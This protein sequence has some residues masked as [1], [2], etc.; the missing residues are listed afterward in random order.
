MGAPTWDTDANGVKRLHNT[1]GSD[2]SSAAIDGNFGLLSKLLSTADSR[3]KRPR[4]HDG[5]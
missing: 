3:V 2:V 4:L 5:P 1:L